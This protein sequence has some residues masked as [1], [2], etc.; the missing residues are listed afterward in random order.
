MCTKTAS[1]ACWRVASSRLS[2]PTAL[3]SKSSKGREAARSWLGWAAV[4]TIS[5]GRSAFR[6]ADRSAVA[7]IQ[8]VVMEVR[9]GGHEPALI[10]ARVALGAEEVGAHV[11]VDAVDLPAELAEIVDDLR[12]DKTRGTCDQ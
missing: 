11:V 7:N 4:W 2:V 9:M 6:A 10:P 8:F 12:A 1:G 5:A 3:T